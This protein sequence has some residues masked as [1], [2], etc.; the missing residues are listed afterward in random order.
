MSEKTPTPVASP[1]DVEQL[2]SAQAAE[3]GTWVAT[4]SI[5]VNGTP[6]YNAG[7][8][9]PVSNVQKFKYDEQGLVSKI[10]TKAGQDVIVAIAGAGSATGAP[11][12]P[13]SL[14]VP[15]K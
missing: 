5:S 11:V 2:R 13:V 14:N 9:V 3:Y 8:P 12:E 7:D 10:T 1:E 4:A 6:A 15:V